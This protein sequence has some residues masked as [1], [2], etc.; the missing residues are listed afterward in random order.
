VLQPEEI[1]LSAV[2]TG[3]R[4]MLERLIG[5]DIHLKT[6]LPSGTGTV[7]AD[8]SQLEQVLLNLVLNARD[9]MPLGGELSIATAAA[10]LSEELA[11]ERLDL[12]P[13]AYVV[14][15]VS[16]S[17][18]GMDAATRE[19]IFEPFFTTKEPDKGTGLGLSTVYGIVKQSGGSVWVYSEP[20]HGTSFKLYFPRYGETSEVMQPRDS[21]GER[22][23]G[24]ETV[25]LVEDDEQARTLV[26][27]LLERL[28]Y[29]VLAASNGGE[30]LA[31]CDRHAGPIALLVTDVVM[32]GMSGRVLAEAIGE[33][34]PDTRVLF[35]SGYSDDMLDH[36]GIEQ[37]EAYL[38]KPYDESDLARKVRE[39]LGR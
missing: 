9:A 24:T 26:H 27:M 1:D 14:L 33:R 38:Q 32:P 30:A 37:G 3:I 35:T 15:S 25:L 31:L 6:T 8:P 20:G 34:R 18:T 29:T 4:P 7:R 39:A 28:G 22:P 12:A 19:R 16:D 17:G 5:E 23:T 2:V 13:G 21:V 36:L 11:R 10:E